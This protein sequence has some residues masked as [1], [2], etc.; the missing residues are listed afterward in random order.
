[1]PPTADPHDK[2]VSLQVLRG[3]SILLVLAQHL[4]LPATVFAAAAGAALAMPFYLGVEV[5]F[6]ISGYVIVNSLARDGYEPLSFLVKRVFRLTPAVLVFLAAAAAVNVLLGATDMGPEMRK[7]FVMGWRDFRKAGTSVVLGYFTLQPRGGYLFGAMW[8][9]SVED[10][11]YAG[12]AVLCLAGAVVTR[13]SH[14]A[15]APV[16]VLGVAAVVSG[17]ILAVRVDYLLGGTWLA[18]L[19]RWAVYLV[20]LKFDFLALGIVLATVDRV[21]KARIARAVTGRGPAL[22]AVTL[23]VPLVVAVFCGNPL[24]STGPLLTGLGMLTAA[25]GFGGLVLVAANTNVLPR[26]WGWPTRLLV[27]FGDRSYTI[28]LLHFPAMAA[29]WVVFQ[30]FVPWAF[31]G[32]YRYGVLQVV[33]TAVIVLPLVELVY[34]GVE[35]PLTAVGRRLA[36]RVRIVPRPADPV[37]LRFPA[38]AAAAPAA[39]AA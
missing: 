39:R 10:Q 37:T 32:P 6:V 16:A 12:L 8:T 15:V 5:F 36:A 19:P 2:L 21:W 18:A 3:V 35:R 28:Y 34:R 23:L 38:P 7:M 14:A 29:A 20:N 27:Y 22:A 13:R 33:V 11:F 9:L 26:G 24:T 17:G 25:A 1:M 4:S 31:G 30:R